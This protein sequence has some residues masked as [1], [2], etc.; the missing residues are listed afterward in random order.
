MLKNHDESIFIELHSIEYIIGMCNEYTPS[1]APAPIIP[2][3]LLRLM[4]E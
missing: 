1:I 3:M 2:S 4:Q